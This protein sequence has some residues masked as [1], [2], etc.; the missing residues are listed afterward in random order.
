[1]KYQEHFPTIWDT[2]LKQPASQPAPKVSTQKPSPI[3]EAFLT[4]WD[5]AK[6]KPVA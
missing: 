1:M 2:P 3:K 4:I 5:N 6:R